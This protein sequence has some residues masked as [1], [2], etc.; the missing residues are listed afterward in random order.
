M[1]YIIYPLHGVSVYI[2]GLLPLLGSLSPDDPYVWSHIIC[3]HSVILY[4]GIKL[5]IPA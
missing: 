3:T 2:R 5:T 1:L 4:D